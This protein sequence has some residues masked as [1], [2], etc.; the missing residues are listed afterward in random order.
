MATKFYK[1]PV[2]KVEKTT[3]DCALITFQ[4][5]EEHKEEFSYKQ[6]QYLTIKKEIK[7]EEVRRSY[8]LCS[9]PLDNEWQV[10]VKKIEDGRF[11]TFA[12]D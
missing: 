12:N 4:V 10:A 1:L 7:G 5:A 3:D 6:G 9:S 2:K 8:S 11:S